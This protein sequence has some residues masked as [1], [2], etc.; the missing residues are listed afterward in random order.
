MTNTPHV[1][2]APDPV[3]SCT[4]VTKTFGARDNAVQ[5]LC[6]VSLLFPRGSFTA[7]V[8]PSG[9]GKSTLL[10]VLAG[11]DT[12]TSGQIMSGG[13]DI[14]TLKDTALTLWRRT[15]CGFIFQAFNLVDIL[16]VQENIELP[17]HLAGRSPDNKRIA[18]LCAQLDIADR[19]HHMP[20]QLSGGQ[21]QRVAIVRALAMQPEVLFADEPTGA[22]DQ[23]NGNTVLNTL[24][25]AADDGQT[26]VLVTH[27]P[28]AAARA[29]TVVV[30]RD[31]L[32]A[33]QLMSPS[34]A[35]VASY[36]IENC[37]QEVI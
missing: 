20:S 6:G 4:N 27:D 3:L 13:T 2:G 10:H 22:L 7:V 35:Q 24:R 11:L 14:T 36:L 32:L 34:P 17:F 37:S 16:T 29:D 1:T 12:V 15:M 25:R 5:A 19:L 28:A 8:G 31:G 30:I 9:S 23:A 26:I 18:T 21:Q 33:T